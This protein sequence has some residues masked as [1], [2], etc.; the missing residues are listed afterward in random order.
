MSCRKLARHPRQIVSPGDSGELLSNKCRTIAPRAEFRT[1]CGQAWSML[2]KCS[3]MLAKLGQ[4]PANMA[5]L[6]QISGDVGQGW[7]NIPH[8]RQTLGAMLARFLRDVGRCWSNRA[9][10]RP[11][12][13]NVGRNWANL[14]NSAPAATVRQCSSNCLS[15]F[16]ARRNRQGNFRGAWRKCARQLL[17]VSEVIGISFK[18]TWLNV[19][20]AKCIVRRAEDHICLKFR[21]DRKFRKWCK[22]PYNVRCPDSAGSGT[23]KNLLDPV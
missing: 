17:S 11:K 14:S 4:N 3:P 9:K 5:E 12:S 8:L 21:H 13:T 22:I 10:L 15:N 7:S 23:N 1:N 19:V 18:S 16:G 2:P 6:G 20:G